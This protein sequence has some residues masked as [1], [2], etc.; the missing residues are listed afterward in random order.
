M[1]SMSLVKILL[2]KLYQ[3]ILDGYVTKD[4]VGDATYILPAKSF[5]DE[6]FSDNDLLVMDEVIRKYGD[7][8]AKEL[9][10]ITHRKGSLWHK[11]AE[12]NN[13]LVPFEN[14]LM[15]NSDCVIDF[16]E[17]LTETG[18]VFYQDQMEFLQMSRAYAKKSSSVKRA[19]RRIL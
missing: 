5:S 7:K 13:L 19:F 10:G 17:E 1:S 15:N 11:V 16:A 6:E 4:V 2:P 14:K 9:V 12:R 3:N 18:K 8:T